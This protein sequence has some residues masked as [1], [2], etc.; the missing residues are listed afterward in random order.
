[1]AATMIK[2]NPLQ[3]LNYLATILVLVGIALMA[4]VVTQL[5]IWGLDRR[6]PFAM[7]GY[8]ANPALPGDVVIVRA[9]VERDLSRKCSVSY[10]RMFFDSAGSRYDITSGAQMMNA[11][12]L[13]DLNRRNPNALVLSVTLPPQATPGKGALV[14]VLDYACNPMHQLFPVPVLLTMDVDVL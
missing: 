6:V 13:D 8:H 4:L 9:V 11:D 14:T 2:H 10:S 3:K 12:A 5:V 1:M 7:T